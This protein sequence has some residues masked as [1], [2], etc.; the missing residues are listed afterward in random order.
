[1]TQPLLLVDFEN[2]QAID[3]ELVPPDYRI[4]IFCGANQKSA[5][6]D[7][8]SRLQPLGSRVQWHRVTGSGKNALDFHLAFHMGRVLERQEA[9]EFV[10]LAKDTGYDPLVAHISSLGVPCRRIAAVG[11]LHGIPVM[12]TVPAPRSPPKASAPASSELERIKTILAKTQKNKRPRKR[13][14][15]TKH[16]SAMLGNKLPEAKLTALIDSMFKRKLVSEANN[17]LS[18]HF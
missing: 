7:L 5:S 11:E 13:A 12:Q 14:T 10:I 4:A 2:V 1:M 18:Y 8:T 15:L 16:V 9:G 17:V 6:L 3:V